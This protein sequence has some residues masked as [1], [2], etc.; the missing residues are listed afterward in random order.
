M[1]DLQIFRNERIGELRTVL[2]DNE[3]HFVGIDVAK[4]LEYAKP[5]QAVI[6]HCKGIRKLG[7]PSEGGMQQTNC[8]TQGDVL[9]LIVKAAD[10]SKNPDIKKKAEEVESWIFDEVIPAVLHHGGYIAGEGN[11]TDDELLAKA[12]VVAQNKIAEREKRI[13]KLETANS[14]LTVENE[15]MRPKSEYFDEL[16]DRNLL[17]NFRDTAKQLEVKEKSFI[18][19]LLDKKY[20]YRDKRGKLQPYAQHVNTGLFEIKECFNDKTAWSGTQT[21]ITPKGRET[22]RLLCIPEK[23]KKGA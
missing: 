20:V 12:F 7:I 18:G 9:R 8:I 19:F 15:I 3:I 6:D 11:L 21:L 2:I 5:S 4:M 13:A 22:F 16:V 23:P 17:T 1:F 14:A 10:Q